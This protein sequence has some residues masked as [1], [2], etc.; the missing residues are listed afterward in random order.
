MREFEV[1][2]NRT[3]NAAEPSV[4]QAEKPVTRLT[5]AQIR[6]VAENLDRLIARRRGDE[7]SKGRSAAA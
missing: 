5:V 3:E 4:R 6:R 1:A 7:P 2:G